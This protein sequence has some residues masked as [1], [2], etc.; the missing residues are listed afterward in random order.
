MN[1]NRVLDAALNS[2]K[3][4]QGRWR[5]EEV[6]INSNGYAE[7]GYADPESGI[8]ALGNWNTVSHYNR[9]ANQFED[10][11]DVMQRLSRILEKMGVE[12]EWNDEWATCDDCGKLVRTSP[13]C[14][15]WQQSYSCLD[16]YFVCHNCIDP[17]EHLENLEGEDDHCNTISHIDPA[18]HNYVKLNDRSF[19]NGL[20]GGQ[21]ATP[22]VIGASLRERGVNRYL[23]SIDS[24]GQFDLGFSVYVHESE[25]TDGLLEDAK[26]DSDEDPADVLK[27]RLANAKFVAVDPE[28]FVN[29]NF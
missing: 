10:D 17:V 14:Y 5:V 21:C 4:N 29:G 18:E 13:D 8:I 6:Q 27:E 19:E 16:G 11:D 9:D 15:G 26:T 28:D 24:V 12:L 25:Y 2:A 23:F 7:P 22:T 20:Y 3:T 1:I